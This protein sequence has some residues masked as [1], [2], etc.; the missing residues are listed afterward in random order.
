MHPIIVSDILISDNYSTMIHKLLISIII[1]IHFLYILFMLFG[2]IFNLY[3]LLF[4]KKLLNYFYLR[5]FHF[6]GIIFVFS[7]ELLWKYC[8]LTFIENYL[9]RKLAPHHTYQ[10]SFIIHYL[11]KIIY[12]DVNPLIII[13]PTGVLA[14]VTL[15]IFIIYPPKKI[16]NLS[17]R[18]FF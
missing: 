5:V 11:E 8:P 12:P 9:Y 13:V 18:I 4:N 14:V 1:I 15:L 10:E 16:K 6:I 17:S 7:L 3:G 2:F